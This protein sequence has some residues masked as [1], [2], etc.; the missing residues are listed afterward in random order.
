M[1]FFKNFDKTV[2]KNLQNM[3]FAAISAYM[4]AFIALNMDTSVSFAYE[5]FD[6]RIFLFFVSAFFL[7]SS[8]YLTKNIF[9]LQNSFALLVF[10]YY[11]YSISLEDR[12]FVFWSIY[13]TIFAISVA[14]WSPF[15]GRD[16]NNIE[17]FNQF[18]K[19]LGALASSV[20]FSLLLIAGIYIA[21]GAFN[22]LFDLSIGSRV[23]VDVAVLVFAIFGANYYMSAIS[24]NQNE[25][26]LNRAEVLFSRYILPIFTVGYFLIL[27]AYSA[28]I[29]IYQ[30]WP[31]GYLAWF[32]LFFSLVAALTY[33]FLTPFETKLK[34]Y[35]LLAIIPQA[36]MLLVA[37]YKRVEQYSFTEDRYMLVVY[38]VFLIVAS[39]Y[40][41]FKNRYKY[42][43]I[44]ASVMLLLVQVGPFSSWSVAKYSQKKRLLENLQIYNDSNKSIETKYDICSSVKYLA[45]R[46]GI[47][48]F[49]DIS[50][51]IVNKYNKLKKKPKGYELQSFICK[52]LGVEHEDKY[53]YSNTKNSIEQEVVLYYGKSDIIDIRGYNWYVKLNG[54][55]KYGDTKKRLEKIDTTLIF[56]KDKIIIQKGSKELIVDLKDFIN[57]VYATK[58]KKL[59]RYI[60][61]NRDIEFK[62]ILNYIRVKKDEIIELNGIL[63]YK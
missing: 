63:F 16:A 33:F 8:V 30:M 56:K 48:A 24:D 32:I 21:L 60:Y 6:M 37:V 46:F 12:A 36:F 18:K 23:F 38:G 26:S 15:Y 41:L 40:L 58:D 14:F 11:Y 35:I 20:M 53:A 47:D 31:N 51:E 1:G 43:F 59:L 44:G 49:E 17:L 9:Y 62:L 27:Y 7:A 39:L 50:T 10:I 55:L 34:K 4:A 52:E 19:V 5:L 25:E 57:R 28:K 22:K 29:L 2:I 61:K 42:L 45:D 54:Y 3:P 13:I